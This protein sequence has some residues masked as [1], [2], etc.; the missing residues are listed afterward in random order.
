MAQSQTT[1][2]CSCGTVNTGKFCTHCGKSRPA[3][4][5]CSC[6]QQGNTGKF[7]IK[8]G[9]PRPTSPLAQPVRAQEITSADMEA[10]T[11]MP[12]VQPKTMAPAVQPVQQPQSAAQPAATTAV[13]GHKSSS[14]MAGVLVAVI[15]ALVGVL[16]YIG[17]TEFVAAPQ[18]AA[19]TTETASSSGAEQAKEQPKPAPQAE[20]PK[21][22]T[23]K[24][25]KAEMQTE[26]ALGGLDAGI[27]VDEMRQRLGKETGVKSY[28]DKPGYMTYTYN[29]LTIGVKDN[30]INT[31][32][33]DGTNVKTKRGLHEGS[34]LQEVQQA[35]GT[36]CTQEQYNGLTL[37]EYTFTAKVGQQGILRFAV[38][39]SDQKV[40]YISARIPSA[41]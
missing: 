35:Y 28:P 25:A 7:C 16:G 4:W 14:K 31:V 22:K 29:G 12:P 24:P 40:D 19:P 2:T 9:Q 20:Q 33:S 5:T 38:R 6:G 13:Q 27:T 39:P 26:V 23:E 21:E 10:T 17:Y 36:N 34:T 1:W 15:V 18:A 41:M 32:V 30:V 8:C 37:Y 11:A 3:S